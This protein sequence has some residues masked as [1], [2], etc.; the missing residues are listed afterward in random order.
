MNNL[1]TLG[2]GYCFDLVNISPNL[3]RLK[4]LKELDLS[5]NYLLFE[6]NDFIAC[7]VY[8]ND[9]A[10]TQNA[11]DDENNNDY[12]NF[13]SY[14][15][16]K[17]LYIGNNDLSEFPQNFLNFINLEEI[18]ISGNLFEDIPLVIHSF[19]NLKILDISSNYIEEVIIK[20]NMFNNLLELYLEYNRIIKLSI[21]DNALQNLE[22][23]NLSYNNFSKLDRNIFQ[24]K[25]LKNLSVFGVIFTE[26]EKFPYVRDD[27]MN[28]ILTLKDISV[29]SNI[30]CYNG[31]HELTVRCEEQIDGEID[32]FEHVP[33]NAQIKYLE[34]YKCFLTSI[35]PGIS[36]L[37]NLEVLKAS[38]NEIIIL[39]NVFTGMTSLKSLDLSFN[40]ITNI[41]GNI[42]DIITLEE[43]NLFFNRIKLLPSNINN[44]RNS[45]LQIDLCMNPLHLG[46]D[47]DSQN[48]ELIHIEQVNR[49]ILG[50]IIYDRIST[51]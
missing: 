8:S 17:I 44:M 36:K 40:R 45:N 37:I 34:F 25:R 48:L 30:F 2:I 15:S 51:P 16:L 18:N 10:S 49:D 5:C 46:I 29:L 50:N 41:D 43:L 11:S 13:V 3:F 42:F 24:L 33:F 1:E 7:S 4:N 27:P 35:S 22:T 26:I 21:S 20:N 38:D 12:T 14:K 47:A 31:I 19:V 9:K 32:I 28:L 39:E 23:F 6:N